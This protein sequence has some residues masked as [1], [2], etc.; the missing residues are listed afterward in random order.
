MWLTTKDL[1]LWVN[2]KKLAP[3]YIS[4]FKILQRISPVAY[5]LI[6]PQTL[7]IN[8]MFHV[9][10]LQTVLCS[11]LAEPAPPTPQLR[12]VGGS[13]AFTVLRILDSRQVRGHYQYLVDWE[14]Y[15]PEAHSWVPARDIMDPKLIRCFRSN[16]VVAL[17][18]RGHS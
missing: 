18:K 3:H 16:R 9:S 1:L 4:P 7:R 14:S 12:M 11:H 5:C 10:Q 2:S 15:G 13:L 17:G 6:L 8:P